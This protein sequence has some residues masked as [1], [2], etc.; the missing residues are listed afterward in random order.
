M[1]LG[2][3]TQPLSPFNGRTYNMALVTSKLLLRRPYFPGVRRESSTCACCHCCRHQRHQNRA[4]SENRAMFW[5]TT[6]E[7]KKSFPQERRVFWDPAPVSEPEIFKSE[8]SHPQHHYL[9]QQQ[10]QLASQRQSCGI[11][12][13]C[14]RR[15]AHAMG[16]RGRRRRGT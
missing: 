5:G 1:E 12:A 15:R 8:L 3:H 4:S 7:W 16:L 14:R 10:Q 2:F 11:G 13:R 6:V 9:Q